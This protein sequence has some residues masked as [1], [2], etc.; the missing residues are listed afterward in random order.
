MKGWI[1]FLEVR[2]FVLCRVFKNFCWKTCPFLARFYGDIF[3][4]CI[5]AIEAETS[6]DVLLGA[7]G[8]DF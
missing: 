4:T 5:F 3:E 6:A 2:N 8:A 1:G 7:I